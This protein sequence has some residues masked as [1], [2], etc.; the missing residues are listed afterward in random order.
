MT[1]SKREGLPKSLWAALFHPWVWQ[2]AW[3]DSR[4]QRFRLFVFSLAIVSGI[5]ALTAI[6]SLKENVKEAM[7]S[8]AK[9]LLGSDLRVSSRSAMT[10]E[11][12]EEIAQQAEQ[13]SREVSFPSMMRFGSD[14]GTRL[15]Q[16]RAIS[17]GFPFYGQVGTSPA[18]AWEAL[19]H[20]GGVIVDPAL[21][22]QF[23]VEI[24]D[25]VVLGQA[26]LRILGVVE[27]PAPRGNRFS[28]F[29][30][31]VYLNFDDL[32]STELIGESS[33]VSYQLHLQLA[34]SKQTRSF[35]K[36]LQKKYVE[37]RWRFES[38]HDRAEN[39]GDAIENLH[40]FLGLI[41]L[42]SLV[43]GAIGV[44]GAV[45]AH[46]TRR[47]ETIAVLRCLGCSAGLAF[48]IYLVQILFLGAFG[49]M[50]G[51]G[52]GVGLQLLLIEVLGE[53]LPLSLQ[54][55]PQWE[56]VVKM[57]LS[58]FAVC[59]GFAI[60]PLL[61][62]REISPASALRNGEIKGTGKWGL[63]IVYLLLIGLLVLVGRASDYSWNKAF[64]M[65]GGLVLAFL[66][67]F[68][69]ARFL[70]FGARWIIRDQWPYLLRQGISNL[71]R[72]GNQTLL[73][74]LSLGLGTFLLVTILLAGNL[75]HE[76]L[77]L[78]QGSQS[79]NLYLIDV[80]PD[81]LEGVIQMIQSEGLPVLEAPPMITMRVQSI[82]GQE[83]SELKDVPRWVSRREFRSTYR[84]HLNHTETVVEGEFAVHHADPNEVVPLS[85]EK[86]I[87]QDMQVNV[88]DEIVMDVQG[89]P[90]KTRVTSIREVDW[91]QF[92]LNFFMVFPTG[93]LEEAPGFHVV[94]TRTPSAESSGRLQRRLVE[95]FANVTAIDLTQIL[96][97]VRGVLDKVSTVISLLAG[98]TLLAGLPIVIGTL[99]N[100]RHLRQLESVLLR[101][102][103]AS[104]RQVRL[105]LVAEYTTLGCLSALSGI[106]L[107][108]AANAILAKFVFKASPWPSA[109]VLISALGFVIL[110][111]L[112]AGFLLSRGICAGKPLEVLRQAHGV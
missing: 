7:A 44:A 54:P 92:N 85:L 89:V 1:R 110:V 104:S 20:Q 53:R 27:K 23:A 100:G 40:Q 58:G 65:V 78:Q 87:A 36:E 69:V 15:V 5:A 37:T 43:L 77:T 8:E 16:V 66:A 11:E 84:N 18:G 6:H 38:S 63:M 9:G 80:Q 51:S 86:K 70:M 82:R 59:C 91:S 22:K 2:M 107:S 48:A 35:K 96:E 83:I 29:A 56:I 17:G 41:A 4:S 73:F 112:A 52:I 62:V 47:R 76:R 34:G 45:H 46:I 12:V 21:L 24:G 39:L 111:S 28:G 97:K 106:A 57:G 88:G 26:T 93:V 81:Q 95:D 49:A 3:R 60:C 103:G 94:T 71:Y 75:L 90:V 50:V 105:I 68:G 19:E 101:T 31:E 99:L 33:M 10:P 109:T 108:V 32:R 30:P 72:P 25:Q 79:P 74:L 14:G 13:I 67:L 64:A 98:F 55:S 61:R 102:L 42:A